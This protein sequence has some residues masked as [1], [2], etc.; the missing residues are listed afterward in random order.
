M[1]DK[2]FFFFKYKEPSSRAYEQF[3]FLMF[4]KSG[5]VRDW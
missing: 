3:L 2:F 1:L 5:S 4:T